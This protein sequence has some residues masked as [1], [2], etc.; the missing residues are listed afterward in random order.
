MMWVVRDLKRDF[1][2]MVRL[3]YDG[4]YCMVNWMV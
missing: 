2:G 3:W 4:I 1:G